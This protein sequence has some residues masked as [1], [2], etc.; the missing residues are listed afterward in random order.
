MDRKGKRKISQPGQILKGKL[1]TG[2]QVSEIIG[3]VSISHFLF[4][5]FGR[6]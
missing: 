4:G 5:F 3:S 2:F 1:E 6:Y